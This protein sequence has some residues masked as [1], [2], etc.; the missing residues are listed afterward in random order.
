MC[1]CRVSNSK[2]GPLKCRR[3][4]SKKICRILLNASV[5]EMDVVEIAAQ[6]DDLLHFLRLGII[7]EDARLVHAEGGV[8]HQPVMVFDGHAVTVGTRN[9]FDHLDGAL[10]QVDDHGHGV[11][12][13]VG[14]IA[15]Q[16]DDAHIRGQLPA[17]E[18]LAVIDTGGLVIAALDGRSADVPGLAFVELLPGG[19]DAG[20]AILQVRRIVAEETAAGDIDILVLVGED[21]ARK[22]GT[23]REAE[24]AGG[25]RDNL[26]NLVGGGVDDGDIDLQ[27]IRAEDN[28]I[29]AGAGCTLAKVCL[30]AKNM[31]LSGLEFA[32][33]IPGSVG[34]AVYMNAGAYNGEIRDV[35]VSVDYMDAEGNVRRMR[36]EELDFS[37]RHSAFT[38]T[39]HV[40]LSASFQLTPASQ[41]QI[42]ERMQEL[43]NRRKD[44]QPINHPSAGSIFKRPEG[45]FA[46]ALIEQCGLKGYAVGGAEVSEKHA[47][48]IVND[49]NA[50]AKDVLSLIEHI[51]KVV[52]EQKNIDL[53]C[54]IR[55]IGRK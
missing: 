54:E 44:K 9:A 43:M 13:G 18:V 48:F 26:H 17:A 35:A 31:S 15:H 41:D 8:I 47:G 29:R 36:Q 42:S 32:W 10:V 14:V 6:A 45:A 25:L 55:F 50:T 22:E 12:G 21:H 7:G 4:R 23:G 30:F 19:G 52:K 20:K 40:I 11:P 28:V 27:V 37:H 39:D 24:T 5:E 34:G 3:P 1:Y 38:D 2:K 33:G 16:L 51:K 46:A 53:T 49:R